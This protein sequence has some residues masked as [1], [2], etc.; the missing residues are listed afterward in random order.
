MGFHHFGSEMGRLKKKSTK[1]KKKQ[2][3]TKA[4]QAKN[5]AVVTGGASTVAI[6]KSSVNGRKRK[7]PAAAKKKNVFAIGDGQLLRDDNFIGKS[8]QFFR[9]VKVELKKV[10]WPSRKQ[11]IGSTV[12]VVVLVFIVALFLG[13]V[14]MGLSHLVQLVLK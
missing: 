1:A 4:N 5:G 9:E 12:V 2:N 6:A 14:D 8:L 3:K 11:T 7:S 10:A 13:I